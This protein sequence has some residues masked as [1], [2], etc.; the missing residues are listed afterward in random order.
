MGL[1]LLASEE[2]F[3]TAREMGSVRAITPA[4]V[5]SLDPHPPG[6]RASPILGS[7][8]GILHGVVFP[9]AGTGA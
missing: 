5:L 1:F 6:R 7:V 8:C 2:G 4:P 3:T 9:E